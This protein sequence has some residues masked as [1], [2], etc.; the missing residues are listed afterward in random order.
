[1]KSWEIERAAVLIEVLAETI[2]CGYGEI[3]G[4]LKDLVISDEESCEIKEII[5]AWNN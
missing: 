1:M 4:N 2:G 3:I 5:A